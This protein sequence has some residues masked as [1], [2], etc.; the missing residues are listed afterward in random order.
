M[1]CGD[2]RKGKKRALGGAVALWCGLSLVA[3]GCYS[4][5]TL[6]A[7]DL[8]PLTNARHDRE[9][10]LRGQKGEAV[11]FGPN[12]QIRFYFLGGTR[13]DWITGRRLKI[14]AQG[15]YKREN[16]KT[17]RVAGWDEI[18]GAQV[19]NLNGGKTY[20]VIVGSAAIAG[21]VI[22]LIAGSKGGGKG[23]GKLGKGLGKLG[24]GVAKAGKTMGRAMATAAKTVGRVTVHSMRT[25]AHRSARS[26]AASVV[27]GARIGVASFHHGYHVPRIRADLRIDPRMQGV[28]VHPAD[29]PPGAGQAGPPQAGLP[30]AGLPQ[31]GPRQPDGGPPG[32]PPHHP[33]AAIADGSDSGAPPP[34][35]PPSSPPAPPTAASSN[36]ATGPAGASAPGF[37]SRPP[38]KPLA[39]FSSSFKRRSAIRL[40][41]TLETG[42]DLVLHDGLTSI[43]LA[44]IRLYDVVEIAAGAKMLIHRGNEKRANGE[45]QDFRASW[46][47][48]AR[49]LAHL[50]LGSR[51]RVA[52]P[53]GIEGGLGHAQVDVRAILGIRFRLTDYLHL[54]IYPFNPAYTRFKD[55]KLKTKLGW[56]SFAT[57]IDLTAAF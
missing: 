12:S 14:S 8:L 41:A 29:T 33:P 44:G 3:A 42:S 18:T 22:L 54:G 31:A 28:A 25:M 51:R 17:V 19:K 6:M 37:D 27:R 36:A 13:S 16:K 49:V 11:R 35:P 23:L 52:L 10:V 21:V 1:M 46:I 2:K 9:L 30:Q 47:A 38:Q 32:H 45:K 20:G 5:T 26:M 55:K 24:K 57:T 39:M 7:A 53:I 15:V 50:D 43:L 48:V 56:W 4:K 40:L 34:P